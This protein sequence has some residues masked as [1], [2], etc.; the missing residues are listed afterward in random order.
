MLANKI[1]N[2]KQCTIVWHVDNLKISHVDSKVVDEIIASLKSEY[3]KVG[4]MSVRRGK[5][6]DYLDT[7]LD[8]SSKGNFI[9][10]ME[11][12]LDDILG[13]LSGEFDGLATTL[14]TDHMFNRA[15]DKRHSVHHHACTKKRA[16]RESGAIP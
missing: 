11:P 15:P 10:D 16:S 1:I 2:G 13:D 8:F 3:G 6:H 4:K 7:T 9:V 12:Y 5:K 14:A